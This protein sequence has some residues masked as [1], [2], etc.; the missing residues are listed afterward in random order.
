MFCV[1]DRLVERTQFHAKSEGGLCQQLLSVLTC[2]GFVMSS[3]PRRF[4]VHK[5]A[6]P[7]EFNLNFIKVILLTEVSRLS[8]TS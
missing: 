6:N 3:P 8:C 7:A 4:F 1:M 5:A 2:Q